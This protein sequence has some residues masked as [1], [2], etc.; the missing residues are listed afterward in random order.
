MSWNDT[1]IAEF[2]AGKPRVADVFDLPALLLL[3]TTGAKSGQER[4]SPL[5]FVAIDDTIVVVA[6]AAGAPKSPDWYFNLVANPEVSIE[7]WHGGE[8]VTTPMTAAVAAEGPDRDSLWERV[9]AVAPGFGDYQTKTTRVIPL[10]R[11]LPRD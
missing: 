9:V 2:H 8:L 10:V 11:L 4:V 7:R 6:S 3:H 1:V 5:A